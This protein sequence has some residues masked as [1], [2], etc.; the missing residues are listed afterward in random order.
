MML[1]LF[2]KNN[3]QSDI[4][5]FWKKHLSQFNKK[6]NLKIPID[7]AKFVVLDVES[8]GLDPKKDKI[9]SIGA[10]KI[11]GN[12][13][14]I[15][16][17]LEIF[18][19]QIEFN[20]QAALIHGILKTNNKEKIQEF[21]AIKNIIEY[22]E[23]SIIIGHSIAFDLSII[24]ETIKKYGGDKLLN[25]SLD[26]VKLYKRLKGADYKETSSTSLD[27]LSDEF[28]IPKSD[29]HNAAG[30]ALI[31]GMLFLKIISR[32]RKRGVETLEDLLK[33]KKVLF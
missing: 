14:N 9:L 5:E 31:T 24:G 18:I 32:L 2:R 22:V 25:K 7:T 12:Q 23:N 3:N 17:T 11:L 6:E 29:R 26:T 33:I 30:D 27:V 13:I 1:N 20:P 28:N 10:V 21:E 15:S 16:N 19:E 8:N 4:P